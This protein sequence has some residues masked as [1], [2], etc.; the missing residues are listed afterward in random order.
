MDGKQLKKDWHYMRLAQEVASQSKCL[1]A[2]Y[3]TVIVD[4]NDRIIST[5]YNGKPAGCINDAICYRMG[6]ESAEHKP[7]CCLHSEANALMYCD[8]TKTRGATLYVNGLPCQ[9]C[10]LLILQAG[11]RRLVYLSDG[12]ASS[13]HLSNYGASDEFWKKYGKEIERVPLQQEDV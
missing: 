6:S 8:A 5:G 1:K 13:G 9:M 10:G 11:I 2:K 12:G 7:H 4:V 3:G